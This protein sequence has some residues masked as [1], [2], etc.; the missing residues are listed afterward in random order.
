MSDLSI[1]VPRDELETLLTETGGAPLFPELEAARTDRDALRARAS[2]QAVLEA[3]APVLENVDAI[4]QTT[5]TLYREFQR[6]G[7]RY[8]YQNPFNLKRNRLWAAALRVFF[9]DDSHLETVHDYTWDVCEETNWVIPAHEN[10]VI[11]LAAVGTGIDLAEMIVLIGDKM[12]DEIVRRV[13]DEIDRRIFEPYLAEDPSLGWYHGTNNWNGV[14]NGGIGAMFLWLEE[15][16]ARLAE[17]LALVLDGLD[18]FLKTAF[19]ADGA[20]TEGTGYWQYGLS[21]VIP[22]AEMLR[23]RTEGEIDLLGL[24]R[25]ADI[26][27]YPLHVVLS[28]GR[29]ASFSD[30]APSISLI[31]GNLVRLAERTGV[32]ELP[33]LM[34]PPAPLSY[35]AA[36][37][38]MLRTMLWW[39]GERPESLRIADAVLP[40]GEVVRLVT[41]PADAP[42]LVLAAKAG[43]NAENHN[44]NDVG[45]F[46]LH[47]DGEDLLCDP[48]RGLYSR[49]YFSPLRYDNIF[50]SAYGHSVPVIGGQLQA[51]GLEFAGELLEVA[52]DEKRAVIAFGD[53][54]P[55]EALERATRTLS[56]DPEAA[57]GGALWIEDAFHFSGDPLPVEEVFVTWADVELDGATATLIGERADVAMTIEAPESAAFA[58]KALEE[59][60]IANKKEGILKRLT[61]DVPPAPQMQARVRVDVYPHPEA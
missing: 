10:R 26:A 30:C 45:S 47:L 46:I 21:N 55:V 40:E 50:A 29:Y 27:A 11:D 7:E 23:I 13:R 39:D 17:G 32:E 4:P 28:P 56:V 60:S 53:A 59:A 22:F 52:P 38:L 18:V 49:Q 1:A 15:D 51:D 31:P 25:M 6:T 12:A 5:Y 42:Q 36:L 3:T 44:Q 33:S 35:S 34:A 37:P 61:F 2:T 19:E 57:P 43:H 9:G 48:G 8:S 41:E 14:C 20:S 58:V 54:Y 24:D 16:P